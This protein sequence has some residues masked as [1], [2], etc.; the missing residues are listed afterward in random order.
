M[1]ASHIIK[2]F[3]SNEKKKNS[4]PMR[5]QFLMVE[6]SIPN[7]YWFLGPCRFLERTEL[8]LASVLVQLVRL[9]SPVFKTMHMP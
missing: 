6:P 3:F 8:I 2:S 5:F 1:S 4:K 7:F 9:A